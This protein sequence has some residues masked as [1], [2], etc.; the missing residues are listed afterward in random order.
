MRL[1]DNLVTTQS[2]PTGVH[3]SEQNWRN[4]R[5]RRCKTPLHRVTKGGKALRKWR[6]EGNGLA[7]PWRRE[8]P[9]PEEEIL[10]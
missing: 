7:P 4:G 8:M 2:R 10:S 1:L 9:R 3:T 6:A 5:E